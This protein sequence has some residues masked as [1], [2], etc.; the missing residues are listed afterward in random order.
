[1]AAFKPTATLPKITL[2]SFLALLILTVPLPLTKTAPVERHF[3]VEASQFAY[4]PGVLRV[5]PGDQVTI[6]LVATDV[7]HGM[8]ID[9]YE[10]QTSADP[11]QTA[12]L[13]FTAGQPGVFRF[14]CIVPCGQLHPFM[15]GK[16]QVGPNLLLLRAVLLSVAGLVLM[17]LWKKPRVSA[18]T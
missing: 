17:V 14:R 13:S 10:L 4:S 9:D 15:L 3:R 2:G 18:T 8:Y 12:T 1:V 7:V 5:N 11:G 16:L 6:E